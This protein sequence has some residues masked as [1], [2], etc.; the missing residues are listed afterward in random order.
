MWPPTVVVES[1]LL[2]L[3]SDSRPTVHPGSMKAV[4]PPLQGVKALFDVVSD[5]VF[6]LTAQSQSREVSQIAVATDEKSAF[7]ASWFSVRR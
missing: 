6:K 1:Q 2:Q 3:V 4:A 5:V 7:E